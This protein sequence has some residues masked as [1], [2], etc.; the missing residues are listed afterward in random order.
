MRREHGLAKR[1][2]QVTY[3]DRW[4]EYHDDERW[5]M[6]SPQLKALHAVGRTSPGIVRRQNRA[7]MDALEEEYFPDLWFKGKSGLAAW[8]SLGLA[9][10]LDC[11]ATEILR[12]DREEQFGSRHSGSQ[13][14]KR[15]ILSP[16][17][18]YQRATLWEIPMTLEQMDAL[19]THNERTHVFRGFDVPVSRTDSRRELSNKWRKSR[20]PSRTK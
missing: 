19:V 17:Q 8:N 16:G 2:S 20:A 1:Y 7:E 13:E 4:K 18:W 15:Y 11:M 5:R 3:E 14:A 6:V 10:K 9:Q 12:R